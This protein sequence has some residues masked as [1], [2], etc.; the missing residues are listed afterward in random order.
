MT[1]TL[2]RT[3]PD[4]TPGMRS[5]LPQPLLLVGAVGLGLLLYPAVIHTSFGLT[6]GVL[7]L[8]AAT[9]ATGWNILGG[10]C[11]QLSFGHALYTATGMYA[12]ALVVGAG[13]SPW[14]GMPLAA[15]AA[16]ALAV[17]LGWPCF[18]L[19]GHQYAIAT[20]T[21]ALVA[22]PIVTNLDVLGAA[23]GLSIPVQPT[24]LGSLQ[25]D[26]RQP[27]AYYYLALGVFAAATAISVLF[28]RGRTGLRLAAIRDDQDAA[29]A[30]GV[31]VLHYK[32]TAA[33]VSAAV[34]SLAGCVQVMVVLLVDPSALDL[35]AS[36]GIAITAL[37]GGAG[38]PWGPLLGA[39]VLTTVQEVSRT[40]LS[41][42]GRSTDLVLYGALLVVIAV[43]QRNG[44]V[45]TCA[46]LRRRLTRRAARS[47]AP[48]RERS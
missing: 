35:A 30:V 46:Q 5:R 27:A 9:A 26:P 3:V 40:Y 29:A 44:L 39:W 42:P 8:I 15:L 38:S 28:L 21:L 34:T 36:T 11:G 18:R 2:P 17:V 33:A 31:P 25:F 14:A 24:G 43:A 23:Q 20:F 4:T 6:V 48:P 7:S 47:T 37:L 19:S 13:W 22:T 10:Y 45:G 16:A 41:L 32:L 1:G 12:T